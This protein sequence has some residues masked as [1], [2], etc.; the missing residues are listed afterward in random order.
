MRELPGAGASKDD[1]LDD[2]PADDA[3]VGGLGVVPEFGLA[4]PLE[5]LFPSNIP[6]PSIQVLDPA[7]EGVELVV[8]VLQRTRLANGQVEVQPDA[9]VLVLHVLPGG[10]A[11]VRRGAEAELVLAGVS[12]REG[13]VTLLVAALGDDAVVIVEDFLACVSI[14]GL[15]APNPVLRQSLEDGAQSTIGMRLTSTEM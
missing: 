11:R 10:A 15:I 13:K 1:E 2:D 6:Q 3:R 4:L 7:R 9:A 14:L 8:L 5:D 12:G